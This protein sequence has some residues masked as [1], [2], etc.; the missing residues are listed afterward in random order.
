MY[1]NKKIY[2][3]PLKRWRFTDASFP[4][5]SAV[6]GFTQVTYLWCAFLRLVTLSLLVS[7]RFH[8]QH[9][10]CFI[11]TLWFHRKTFVRQ[12]EGMSCKVAN[13]SLTVISG[14]NSETWL[15]IAKFMYLGVENT[16]NKRWPHA[17]QIGETKESQQ[18]KFMTRRMCSDPRVLMTASLNDCYGLLAYV[19]GFFWATLQASCAANLQKWTISTLI[20]STASKTAS[21]AFRLFS[22]LISS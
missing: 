3:A 4:C 16:T 10:A 7:Q 14:V 17:S 1:R 11:A 15:L 19:Q 21:Q 18:A 9:F 22:W 5:G 2:T 6:T 8:Y 13:S 20:L 12:P